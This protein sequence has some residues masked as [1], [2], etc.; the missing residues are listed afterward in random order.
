MTTPTVGAVDE[1]PTWRTRPMTDLLAKSSNDAAESLESGIDIVQQWL[2]AYQRHTSAEDEAAVAALFTE[3]A[4][5]R[6]L[7]ALSWDFRNAVG[8][9]E[10]SS[11]LTN[12][13]SEKVVAIEVRRTTG[14]A[15]D[16]DEGCRKVEGSAP[17]TTV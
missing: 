16:E 3:K 8:P 6:D 14:P 13:T 10:I 15:L 4:T 2:E 17:A 12:A 5:A 11:L 1:S 9:R 7:L